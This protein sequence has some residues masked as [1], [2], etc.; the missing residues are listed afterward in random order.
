MT[1]VKTWWTIQKIVVVFKNKKFQKR[2]ELFTTRYHMC[3]K[4]LFHQHRSIVLNLLYS[5]FMDIVAYIMEGR[6]DVLS[7]WKDFRIQRVGITIKTQLQYTFMKCTSCIILKLAAVPDILWFTQKNI[8]N[9]R[10]C[11]HS[12]LSFLF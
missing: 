10:N 5:S 4:Q 2:R 11:I 1:V 7:M 8:R 6:S 9:I 3:S 12:R